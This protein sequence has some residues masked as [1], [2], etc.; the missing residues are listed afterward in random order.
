MQ[1][2]LPQHTTAPTLSLCLLRSQAE[3]YVYWPEVLSG[4]KGFFTGLSFQHGSRI[5]GTHQLCCPACAVASS[6]GSCCMQTMC[7]SCI[8]TAAVVC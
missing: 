7:S 6:A 4:L 8:M 3:L 2:V 1:Q 5:M